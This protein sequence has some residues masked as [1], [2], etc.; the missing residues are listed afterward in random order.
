MT[1]IIRVPV[2]CSDTL[3][4][5]VFTSVSQTGLIFQKYVFPDIY[6]YDGRNVS[7]TSSYE[8]SISDHSTNLITTTRTCGKIN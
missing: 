4:R 7:V 1:I 3:F 8:S 6:G 5:A 2:E